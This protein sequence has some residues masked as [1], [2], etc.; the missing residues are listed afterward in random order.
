MSGLAEILDENARLRQ[1]MVVLRG[2]LA[3][4]RSDLAERDEM[5]A[6]VERKAEYL[7]Q[8]LELEQSKHSRPVSQRFIPSEQ[9]ALA[10]TKDIRP[11]PRA[12]QQQDTENA[13]SDSE[14]PVKR[15]K[16]KGT[17]R[18]RNR[19]AFAHLPSASV[20]CA[21]EPS[22]C[23]RCGGPRSVIGQAESFRIDWVPGHFIRHDVSRDKCACPSCPSEGILTVSGPYVL[24]RSLAANGLLARVLIDKFA[25]HIPTNRQVGRMKR[26]GFEVGSQ[27][28]STWICGVGGLLGRVAGAVC[29]QLLEKDALQGDDTGMNVQDGG[30]GALR[31]G[32]MWA[33]TDQDQVFYGFTATKEGKF[34]NELLAGFKGDLL[35]V[36]G[37]SEFNE[38]VRTQELE[39]AG[40][41]SHLRSYFHR[42]LPYHPK[43]VTLAL[44]TMK[45]LFLIERDIWGKAPDVVR[46][47]RQEQSKPLVDGLYEWMTA[48]STITRPKS[49]LGEALRYALNQRQRMEVFLDRG[50]VPMHNN[51]SELMLRQTVVGRKNWLFA[52]SEGG[53]VAAANIYTLIGSCYL[54]SIDPWVYLCDILDRLQDHPSTRIDELTPMGWRLARERH[55]EASG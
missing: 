37:G 31:K 32:R 46:T 19:Q 55:I 18:R 22:V 45:D 6:A 27:T 2:E 36:D 34:P 50:D 51:L 48:L 10:F 35:L 24:N 54:Q 42:A 43:E 21:A 4:T 28:V 20:H 11:P 5:L 15:S 16:R 38:V 44:G 13:E 33:F 12:P 7:A 30:N 39:R 1:Q 52:R 23:L 26:E 14:Q 3:N 49:L 29:A 8:R 40:C 53:A 17:P 25:D 9:E 41:W 47:V